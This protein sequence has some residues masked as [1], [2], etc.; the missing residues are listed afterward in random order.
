MN[1]TQKKPTDWSHIY[2][3]RRLEFI[4]KNRKTVNFIHM[5]GDS[6]HENDYYHDFFSEVVPRLANAYQIATGS[7]DPSTQLGA[8]VYSVEGKILGYGR[9]E[10]PY[11]ILESK[12]RY[13]NRDTKYKL[14]QHAERSALCD[15]AAEGRRTSGA[16]LYCP[17]FSCHECAKSIISSG[18]K[19]VIGHYE[20]MMESAD[21][22]HGEWQ[23][24]MNLAF[25]MFREANVSFYMYKGPVDFSKKILIHGHE[26]YPNGTK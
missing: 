12:Q 10:F 18:I 19:C 15:C 9:N 8:F 4:T 22:N 1:K 21:I 2:A 6:I 24:S 17:W 3:G 14:V 20:L 16:C 13:A 5:G 26:F 11:G 25:G 23:E 7:K